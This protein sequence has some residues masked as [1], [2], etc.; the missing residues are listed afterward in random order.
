[1][2]K[3]LLAAVLTC[4]SG[5]YAQAA[6]TYTLDPVIV[7]A[8]ATPVESQMKT[9]A[10]VSVISKEDIETKHYKN[11]V[12]VLEDIPGVQTMTP[13]NGIGFEVSGYAQPTMRGIS[14]IVFLIDGVK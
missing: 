12:D 1:M 10:A 2:N 4:C 3:V 8:T 7:T 6:T 11:M 5:A 9:Q 13:A 14:R